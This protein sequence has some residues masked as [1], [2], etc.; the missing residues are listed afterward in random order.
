M[1]LKGK[2]YPQN[3]E[4]E[5]L[6]NA[7]YWMDMQV[8]AALALGAAGLA[9]GAWLCSRYWSS[10]RQKN[11]AEEA[12]QEGEMDRHPDGRKDL[13][14]KRMDIQSRF[15]LMAQISHF[16]THPEEFQF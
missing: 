5:L 13:R 6:V 15:A 4:N 10:S 2:G 8:V 16:D 7:W 1:N 9:A 14:R 3:L 11:E 12:D